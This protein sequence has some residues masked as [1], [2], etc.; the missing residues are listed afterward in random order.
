MAPSPVLEGNQRGYVIPIG[1]G[2]DKIFDLNVLG[3]YVEVCGDRN[4]VIAIIPTAS[5]LEDTGSRYEEVFTELGAK[6]AVSLPINERED[7][8]RDDYLEILDSVTGIFITG[9]N[10]LRLS[11]ILGGTPIFQ[12]IRK[13]NACGV[14]VG[15][16]SAGAAIM[17][18]HMIAG[19]ATGLVPTEDGV[20]LAPGLGLTNSVVID[21]HFNERSRLGRLLVAVSYNPFLTGV[22]LDEDTS[23]FIGP[24]DVMEVVGSGGVTIIDASDLRYSSMA[25]AGSGEALTLLG[26]KLHLLA[27]A[28]RYNI[29]TREAFAPK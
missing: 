17:P 19:G 14:H 7:A 28:G 2:E 5:M 11:T 13:L 16:T 9:G 29:K 1:G 3:R 10:Q 6:K 23:V 27:D 21:Q 25:A 15:G 22:G 4:A 8:Q 12:K 26:L 20:N 18:E 24:D